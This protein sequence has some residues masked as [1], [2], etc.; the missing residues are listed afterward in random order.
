[1]PFRSPQNDILYP[2]IFSREFKFLFSFLAVSLNVSNTLV[3]SSGFRTAISAVNAGYGTYA[4]IDASG[5]FDATEQQAAM[6]RMT[7]AGV[8]VYVYIGRVR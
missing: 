6:I 5:A 2:A 1:M 7:Q 4:A 8:I 3:D